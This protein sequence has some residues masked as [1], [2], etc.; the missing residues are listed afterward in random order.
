VGEERRD[1]LE[2]HEDHG[3]DPLREKI[4]EARASIARSLREV[5][6]LYEREEAAALQGMERR[7]SETLEERLRGAVE[8][9]AGRLQEVAAGALDS[10]EEAAIA[11][12]VRADRAAASGVERIEAAAERLSARSDQPE[13]ASRGNLAQLETALGHLEDCVHR[14]R[15]DLASPAEGPAGRP[16][17]EGVVEERRAREPASE[18]AERGPS[19][20][21]AGVRLEEARARIEGA[22]AQFAQAER[23]VVAI[24][25]RI[26]AVARV[27]EEASRRIE[28]VERRILGLVGEPPVDRPEGEG[29][30]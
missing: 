24:E 5:V 29:E 27:E 3:A 14:A 15:R 22:I 25:T 21:A 17:G 12:T 4:A 16:Q 19:P 9:A 28:E 1:Q 20:G 2:P 10:L 26:G 11:A 18:L 30:G 7:L 6:E 13:P 8:E 23:R